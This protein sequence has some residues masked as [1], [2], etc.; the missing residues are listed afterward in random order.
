MAPSRRGRRAIGQRA[1]TRALVAAALL[2]A[3]TAAAQSNPTAVLHYTRSDAAE[4]CPDEQRLRD[5]VAA[6]LGYDPFRE[7]APMVVRATIARTH[8]RLR[9]RIAVTD[10]AGADVGTREIES[11][12]QDCA[13]IA[14]AMALA[15]SIVIDPLSLTRPPP[16]PTVTAPPPPPPP[17]PPPAAP[18]VQ[19]VAP[20]SP[21]V[22]P[23]V[24]VVAERRAPPPA[25]RE[26]PPRTIEAALGAGVTLGHTPDTT[27]VLAASVGLRWSRVSVALE[28]SFAFLSHASREGVGDVQATLA[29]GRA[30]PC[31]RQRFGARVD[32]AVCGVLAL[33]ALSGTA[34]GV[35]VARPGAA[36]H[37]AAGGRVAVQVALVANVAVRGRAEL[38]GALTPT[39]LVI[40]N[41][42]RDVVVWSTATGA[43]TA[44]ID[45][46]ATFP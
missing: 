41:G 9:G 19:C 35:D 28:G 29:T 42:G 18:P 1:G 22:P 4:S 5:T 6:R 14:S 27:A 24:I 30:V 39:D 3:P 23:P 21:P 16:P 33:G 38:L 13:E 37:A 31:L 32:G 46:V 43:L 10:A 8:H 11:S 20:P 12:R 45:V 40:R 7:A 17:T 15:I 25:P 36:L 2:G 34:T 26:T 44:A